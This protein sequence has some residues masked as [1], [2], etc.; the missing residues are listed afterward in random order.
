MLTFAYELKMQFFIKGFEPFE[1]FS[2]KSLTKKFDFYNQFQPIF[3]ADLLIPAKYMLPLF[4]NKYNVYCNLTITQRLYLTNQSDPDALAPIAESILLDHI[5]IPFFTP[6]SFSNA[7]NHDDVITV[8]DEEPDQKS[9]GYKE[10]AC[11]MYSCEG[12]MANK[13]IINAVLSNGKSGVDVGTALR[14]IIEQVTFKE[15]IVDKPDNDMLFDTIVLP[16]HN[17]TTAVKDL[18]VRYGIYAGGTQVFWDTPTLYILNKFKAEHDFKDK[19]SSQSIFNVR[20]NLEKA[21]GITNI[22]YLT[23]KDLEYDFS[24]I[25]QKNNEDV[26]NAELLGDVLMYSSLT[27]AS[28]VAK[29]KE[30]SLEKFTRPLQYLTLPSQ[31]HEKTG[32]KITVEY[33]ELNN[34]FNM[35]AFAKAATAHTTLT[36]PTIDNV[37]YDT[38]HPNHSIIIKFKDD[39]EKDKEIGG[40]YG[41]ISGELIFTK[42][43]EELKQHSLAAQN[44][45]LLKVDE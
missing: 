10:M 36:F 30:G 19:T 21:G 6:N 32:T 4:K 16:P 31:K 3:D 1:P 8:G 33:D 28:N 7:V 12:L 17:L 22:N 20:A 23:N 24:S 14:Y 43:N 15:V 13:S 37:A 26:Y 42:V 38:F 40:T 35:A 27:L 5:Y 34:P 18:Q 44:I 45:L 39:V 9:P 25:P 41:I 29:Y 11:T 2:I